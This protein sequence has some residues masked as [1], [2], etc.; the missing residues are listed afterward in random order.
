MFD[1]LKISARVFYDDLTSFRVTLGRLIYFGQTKLGDGLRAAY[2]RDVVRPWILATPPFDQTDD[3][4]YEIHVL[5][6]ADDWINLLWALKTFYYWSGRRYALCIHDDGTLTPTAC[7]HLRTAFPKARIIHRSES[8]KRLEP[9]LA[10]YPRSR[11]FRATNKLALKVFDFQAYLEAE[12]LM[13]LDSDILFFGAPSS[14]LALIEDPATTF[15]TLNKDW[16][17][18]YSFETELVQPLL[19]FTLPPLINAG[20]G[21]IHRDS[22]R[23]EWVEE[24]LVLP[25]IMSHSHQIEQTLTALCSARFGY[26]MLPE[27]YDVHMGPRRPDAPSRH[28]TGPIRHMMYDEGIRELVRKGFFEALRQP[29]SHAGNSRSDSLVSR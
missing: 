21:L 26:R 14:L 9:M 25:G 5:T 28:Y 6:S 15:N 16:R 3:T 24:F 8:D 12:R 23:F 7:G 4:R 17:P 20:L 27:E 13:L 2:Y 1:R 18:G 29:N 19:D 11:E 10:A 22:V